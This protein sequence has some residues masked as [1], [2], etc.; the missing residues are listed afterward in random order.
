VPLM[1][2]TGV[3]LAATSITLAASP[4][5]AQTAKEV[6]DR[7]VEVIGGREALDAIQTIA[8]RGC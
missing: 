3:L 8:R 4:V 2:R 1:V 6:V 7:Y 5:E